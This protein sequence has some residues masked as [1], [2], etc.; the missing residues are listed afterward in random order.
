MKDKQKWMKIIGIFVGILV[1]VIIIGAV[2]RIILSDNKPKT[3]SQSASA[4]QTVEAQKFVVEKPQVPQQQTVVLELVKP[5]GLTVLPDV[6]PKEIDGYTP[7]KF[8]AN[9]GTEKICSGGTCTFQLSYVVRNGAGKEDVHQRLYDFTP[10]DKLRVYSKNDV[11]YFNG[12]YN[13]TDP[14]DVKIFG[15]PIKL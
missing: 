7:T 13:I 6:T 3:V 1:G 9:K 5:P 12:F 15:Q 14:D 2:I 4:P 11:Y 8:I 10:T